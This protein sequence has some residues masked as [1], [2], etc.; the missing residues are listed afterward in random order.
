MH[1]RTGVLGTSACADLYVIQVFVGPQRM[2]L[3]HT[4]FMVC[5]YVYVH[6]YMY[7]HA[8]V[9]GY[10]CVSMT[11]LEVLRRH[12]SDFLS[13]YRCAYACICIC[14]CMYACMCAR[15]YVCICMC[16]YMCI[17]MHVHVYSRVW[18]YIC[19]RVGA[20][21]L[22]VV[23][24]LSTTC[25]CIIG[26]CLSLHACVGGDWKWRFPWLALVVGVGGYVLEGIEIGGLSLMFLYFCGV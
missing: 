25:V 6:I 2:H 9:Y 4:R 16:M 8:Y 7:A 11:L 22:F 15:A 19:I 17:C 24:N 10:V 12:C 13:V 26:V 20:F 1:F 18:L 23:S 3:R 5:T 14:A 21:C